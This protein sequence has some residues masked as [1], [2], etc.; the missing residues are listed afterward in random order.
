MT[1]DEDSQFGNSSPLP[2]SWKFQGFG[3]I[4]AKFGKF[5]GN[6][7]ELSGIQWGFCMALNMTS[8]GIPGGYRGNVRFSGKFVV[9]GGFG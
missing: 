7:G 3:G 6:S 5:R 4:W 2:I 8:V 9:W 1:S